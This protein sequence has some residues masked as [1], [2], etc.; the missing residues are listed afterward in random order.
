[1]VVIDC[2]EVHHVVPPDVIVD[3]GEEEI[4]QIGDAAAEADSV[5]ALESEMRI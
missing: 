1:M 5:E 3:G 4:E 2:Q